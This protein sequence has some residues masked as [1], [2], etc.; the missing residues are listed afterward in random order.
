VNQEHDN[1]IASST[2]SP[3]DRLKALSRELEVRGFIHVLHGNDPYSVEHCD[4]FADF[5]T[6]WENMPLDKYM[7]DGG[8]YRRRR[9]G[10]WT[11]NSETGRLTPG[12]HSPFLQ[13]AEINAFAGGVT[14]LFDPLEPGFRD[15]PLLHALV[16]WFF[17]LL[18]GKHEACEWGVD[19]HPIRITA[20]MG[21][22]G[23]PTPEGVHR[24]GHDFV[25]L[26]FIRRSLEAEGGV[27]SIYD[28][29]RKNLFTHALRQPLEAILVDDRR[30]LHSASLLQAGG[31]ARTVSRDMLFLNYNAKKT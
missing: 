7:K 25:A 6:F 27:S 5:A 10:C 17:N 22:A 4:R 18:P 19:A 20:R 16:G 30:V 11:L 2:S 24:D 15:H 14:R 1:G 9:F 29:E 28:L 31:A 13:S 3:S 12:T 26:I 21:E 8:T 23:N